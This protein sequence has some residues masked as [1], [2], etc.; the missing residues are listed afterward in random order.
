[1]SKVSSTLLLLL[2]SLSILVAITEAAPKPKK[3]KKVKCKDK[4]YPDC[5]NKHLYCPEAC[6]TTCFVDCRTCQPLCTQPPPSPPPR[7]LPPPATTTYPPPPPPQPSLPLPSP[8]PPPIPTPQS[9]LPPAPLLP[10]PPPSSEA[11]G[12]KRV[13]C[14][15]RNYPSCYGLE[16]TCPSACPDQCEVDCVTCSP[17]CNCNRPGA[18]CQDPR[19]IGGDGLTFYFHGKKDHD[20]CLVSDSNLHINA[21][22]IGKRSPNMT[23]DFTWVQSLGILFDNHKLFIGAKKTSA[24]SDAAD[25]LSLAFDGEPILLP[26]GAGA[27]WQSRESSVAVSRIEDVN[28]VQMEVEGNFKIKATVVPIT[29]KES[30]IHRYGITEEDCFAHLDVSLKFYALSGEVN[31]VLGQT[32]GKNY[33]SRVKMGVAM[34]VLGG[35]REFTASSLF[36]ADCAAARFDGKVKSGFEEFVGM[37]CGSGMGGR[38]VVCKK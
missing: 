28:S 26:T 14:R 35:E 13:R 36:A 34:P 7:S 32:Y 16:H 23:R 15:N 21:H 2:I 1:M 10:P 6:P 30:R 4:W 5:F 19:F 17:V 27:T 31:G 20:F 25:R 29:E 11:A 22:F 33:V 38:G 24:W 3:P 18:V 8:P 12:G 9:P 37:E